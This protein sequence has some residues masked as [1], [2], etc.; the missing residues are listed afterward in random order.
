MLQ[1][2]Q[3]ASA[4]QSASH[5]GISTAK[6]AFPSIPEEPTT[7]S[8]P[9]KV[10]SDTQTNVSAVASAKQNSARS[11]HGNLVSA[12]MPQLRLANAQNQ[13][14][15]NP[16]LHMRQAAHPASRGGTPKSPPGMFRRLM[17][18]SIAT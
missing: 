1:V 18:S 13:A 15:V 2:S 4:L 14:K 5:T 8:K 3:G 6:S 10:D 12:S 17:A 7:S 16:S 11:I 9:K